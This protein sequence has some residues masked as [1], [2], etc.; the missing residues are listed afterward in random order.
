MVMKRVENLMRGICNYKL[1]P[2]IIYKRN[3]KRGV[4]THAGRS[5]D[6]GGKLLF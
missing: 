1:Q 3:E 4:L 5:N 6:P 2:R